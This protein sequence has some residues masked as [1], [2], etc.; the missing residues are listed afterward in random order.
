MTSI[1]PGGRIEAGPVAPPAA[2]PCRPGGRADRR[3]DGNA[4]PL[5]FLAYARS[6]RNERLRGVRQAILPGV[7]ILYYIVISYI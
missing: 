7:S 2:D 5:F 1:R 3:G 6:G 4:N